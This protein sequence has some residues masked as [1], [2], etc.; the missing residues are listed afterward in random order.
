MRVVQVN[1]AFDAGLK[2]TADLLDA[3]TTLTGWAEALA[4]AGADVLTVQRF[5]SSANVTRSRLPYVFGAD[6]AM[7][8]AAAAFGPDVLHVNGLDQ[9]RAIVTKRSDHSQT[10]SLHS[11]TIVVQDHGSMPPSGLRALVRRPFPRG[12]D[13]FL[14]TTLA[15]AQPWREAGLIGPHQLVYEV[16][17]ASTTVRAIPCDEARAAT[18][19]SGDPAVIWIGR[20]NA[21]KDPLTALDGFARFASRHATATLTMLFQGGE[22]SER[23]RDRIVESAVLRER[24]RL[25]GSIPHDRVA[26]FLS[27]ADVFVSGSHHE[28]SGYAVLE[29]LACGATPAVTDIPPFRAIGGNV[30]SFWTPGDA[31]ACARALESAAAQ[32]DRQRVIEHFE[33]NLTWSAV[34]KR[35]VEIYKDVIRAK[36]TG[37]RAD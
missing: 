23:V 30:G 15:Q 14:F 13:A 20:L 37:Q 36:G 18:E 2:S 19:I 7:I 35:A 4:A 8:E 22:L 1:Y 5:H 16:L 6:T 31:D 29:A 33:K 10:G 24:V 34:G 12:V 17:E 27:A 25:V 28:G 26:V 11:A 3:Y 21:N 9:A 32:R